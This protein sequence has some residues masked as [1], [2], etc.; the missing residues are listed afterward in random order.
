MYTGVLQCGEQEYDDYLARNFRSIGFI[1][2][3]IFEGVITEMVIT[4]GCICI[5][6]IH[7]SEMPGVVKLPSEAGYAV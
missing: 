6:I 1:D 3:P 7:I 5:L 2:L 4:S